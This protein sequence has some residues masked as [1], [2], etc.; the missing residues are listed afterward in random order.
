MYNVVA[1]TEFITFVCVRA[2][3]IKVQDNLQFSSLNSSKR[4]SF[5]ICKNFGTKN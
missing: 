4:N 1:N 2:Q 5:E 3:T